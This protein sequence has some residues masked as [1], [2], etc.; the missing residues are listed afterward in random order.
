MIVNLHDLG[1]G[2][3]FLD[4]TPKAQTTKENLDTFDFKIK[5]S[6]IKGHY[7]ESEKT[8]KIMGENIC[9]LYIR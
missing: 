8:A 9:K 1:L 5:N 6:C 4:T 7:Q 2:N 3:N